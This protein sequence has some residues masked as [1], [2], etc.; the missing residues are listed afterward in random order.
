MTNSFS[1]MTTTKL[2]GT[3]TFNRM[4]KCSNIK[5]KAE[6]RVLQLFGI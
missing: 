4:T 1:L 5:T 6:E 3:T 2:K